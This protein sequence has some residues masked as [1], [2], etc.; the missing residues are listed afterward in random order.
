[1]SRQTLLD[2]SSSTLTLASWNE[3]VRQTYAPVDC[4][5]SGPE[6]FSARLASYEFCG[7]TVTEISTT[8]ISYSRTERTIR[9]SPADEFQLTIITDGEAH[10]EQCER[11]CEL[12]AGDMAIYDARRPFHLDFTP[13][14]AFTL[15]IPRHRIVKHMP[16]ADEMTARVLKASCPFASSLESIIADYIRMSKTR[17]GNVDRFRLSNAF[18]DLLSA[19]F[20]SE[21][22][23]A[24]VHT[25]QRQ[26]LR[27]A[28]CFTMRNHLDDPDFELDAVCK[29]HNISARTLARLFE[30]VGE[31]PMQWLWSERLKESKAALEE[32]RARNVTEA[33]FT[34]GF[35]DVS[36]FTRKFRSVFGVLPSSVLREA[37]AIDR[38]SARAQRAR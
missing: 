37:L 1:M 5:P 12:R 34:F 7:T 3:I 11:G 27:E 32:G 28:V 2:P 17:I 22:G 38:Q 13:Y 19:A 35:S 23:Y 33:A 31:T 16:R 25:S 4:D 29:A 15:K 14:A 18:F 30:E 10:I 36:H 8:S 20:T 26:V 24:K 9:V 6:P 21:Q